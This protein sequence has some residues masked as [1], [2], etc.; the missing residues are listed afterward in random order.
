LELQLVQALLIHTTTIQMLGTFSG[1]D[2][3][4]KRRNHLQLVSSFSLVL[5][6]MILDGPLELSSENSMDFIELLVITD[7]LIME[8]VTLCS[9]S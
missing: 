5:V 3:K 1:V 6:Q 7:V 2:L 8:N 4:V 9:I